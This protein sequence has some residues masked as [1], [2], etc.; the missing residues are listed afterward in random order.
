MKSKLSITLICMFLLTCIFILKGNH[1]SADVNE[2]NSGIIVVPKSYIAT[3]GT[4]TFLGPLANA[5]RTYQLLIH[6]SELTS[7]VG[8]MIESITFRIPA[9]ATADWPAAEVVYTTYDIY[10][11]GSVAPQDRSLTF[12]NNIVGVQ[13]QVRSGSMTIPAN[14]YPS[15]GSPNAFGREIQF[16]S[17][18]LY[19][20]GHL[21]LAIRHTGFSGTS[22]SVDAISTT[23]SGYGTLFS[24]CWTGSYTGTS[25]SQ[26][27]FGVLSIN[28][29][30]TTGISEVSA[31]P[32]NYSLSQN[33]P[34]PFNPV[35]NI[36]FSIPKQEIVKI[37]VYNSYG[38]EI[39]VLLNKQLA[40]GTYKINFYGENLSSGIYFYKMDAEN[41]S[42]SKS[43]ILLK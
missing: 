12:T 20:G 21:L 24:A 43:M 34:N 6:E 11:S 1:A 16:D 17:M 22:R 15:G 7:I 32:D 37:T 42:Q 5:Q 31:I 9:S 36:K 29:Q 4:S 23:T 3:P 27:N 33:Y 8:N 25:G 39:S 41:F 35:T 13:K 30:G 40:A 19:T 26:G 10:L 14:S 28:S 38:K 2:I 18:Y